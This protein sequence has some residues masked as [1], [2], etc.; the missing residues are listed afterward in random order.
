MASDGVLK[1][2]AMIQS[3]GSSVTTR[4]EDD[5]RAGDPL[6]PGGRLGDRIAAHRSFTLFSA[7]T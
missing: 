6:L 2:V 7:F 5:E 1:P 3:S 4:V